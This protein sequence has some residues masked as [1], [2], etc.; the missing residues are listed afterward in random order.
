MAPYREALND[1]PFSPVLLVDLNFDMTLSATP[2][3]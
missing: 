3:L 1:L 2:S